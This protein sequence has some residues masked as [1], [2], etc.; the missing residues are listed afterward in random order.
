MD[1]VNLD[2]VAIGIVDEG[3][4]AVD[5]VHLIVLVI[6]NHIAAGAVLVDLQLHAVFI[7]VVI[8]VFIDIG[9]HDLLQRN[10]PCVFIPGLNV[11]AHLYVSMATAPAAASAVVPATERTRYCT[12]RK[13]NEVTVPDSE[14][15]SGTAVLL[16]WFRRLN[17]F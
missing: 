7:V 13:D 3:Q 9:F 10:I 6:A 14:V 2:F 12:C 15:L 5:K 8:S 1:V 16:Q 17:G 4:V 11:V